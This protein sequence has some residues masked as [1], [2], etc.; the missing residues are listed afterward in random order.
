MFYFIH[1]MKVVSSNY[2]IIPNKQF[3]KAITTNKSVLTETENSKCTDNKFNELSSSFC[4]PAF[5]SVLPKISSDTEVIN[6]IGSLINEKGVYACDELYMTAI[7]KIINKFNKDGLLRMS[8]KKT[9]EGF[10]LFDGE[11]MY[12]VAQNTL[13]SKNR[14]T[15]AELLKINKLPDAIVGT[16]DITSRLTRRA[17]KFSE[18]VLKTLLPLKTSNGEDRFG[19]LAMYDIIDRVVTENDFAKLKVLLKN[20]DAQTFDII[21]CLEEGGLNNSETKLDSEALK[22][23]EE[24]GSRVFN[25]APYEYDLRSLLFESLSKHPKRTKKMIEIAKNIKTNSIDINLSTFNKNSF[26]SDK[27]ISDIDNYVIKNKPYIKEFPTGTGLNN[28]LQNLPNGEVATIGGKLFANECGKMVS[29]KMTPQK[30][31]ELFP[32]IKRFNFLQGTLGDCWLISAFDNIMDNPSTR[33]KLYKLFRQSGN[34]IYIKFPTGKNEI[35]FKDSKILKSN[36]IIQGSLGFQMLEQA[37]SI[38]RARMYSNKP[39]EDI[40]QAVK[41]PDGQLEN[42]NWG[43]PVEAFKEMLGGLD[44]QSL[45]GISLTH[46]RFYFSLIKDFANNKNYLLNFTMNDKYRATDNIIDEAYGLQ[47]KHSYSIKAY[48][49]EKGL[50]QITNPHNSGLITEVPI[51][52][53]L[54]YVQSLSVFD[55]SKQKT[56]C[57]L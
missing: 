34:D 13:N 43:N 54:K 49:S 30:F 39:F 15:L 2:S 53:L 7:K 32:P 24:G 21:K 47:A 11:W 18:Q 33:V 20:E 8:E 14:E 22:F 28:I 40:L 44:I 50:V 29:L 46:K 23:F 41:N 36:K 55:L 3:N 27:V 19:S 37:Y 12:Q 57:F 35:K 31:K 48:N 56:P 52:E 5:G 10:P 42:L 26:I 6:K 4:N 9:K 51:Y 16:F 38:H 1:A 45:Y 25:V 17:N